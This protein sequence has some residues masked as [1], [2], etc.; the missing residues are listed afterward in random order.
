MT[1]VYDLRMQNKDNIKFYSES[2]DFAEWFYG[3][4]KKRGYTIYLRHKNNQVLLID[5][6]NVQSLSISH[7]PH[8]PDDRVNL[9]MQQYPRPLELVDRIWDHIK[10]KVIERPLKKSHISR[11]T[12]RTRR[13]NES[14]TN[15]KPTGGS[16]KNNAN[17]LSTRRCSNSI[18]SKPATP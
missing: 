2:M 6:R 3:K 15:R 18:A 16:R 17:G 9:P 12:T 4:K 7:I 10:E 13:C 11:C 14:I 8:H 5:G 1:F